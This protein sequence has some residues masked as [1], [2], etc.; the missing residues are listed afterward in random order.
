M[1]TSRLL[2]SQKRRIKRIKRRN[3]KRKV[4]VSIKTTMTVRRVRKK[5]MILVFLQV[6]EKKRIRSQLKRRRKLS[7]R[8]A[9]SR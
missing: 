8:M 6:R 4:I 7:I 3:S 2:V 5:M 1:T 9:Q